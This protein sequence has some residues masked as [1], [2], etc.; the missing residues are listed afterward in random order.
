MNERIIE[1]LKK[2]DLIAYSILTKTRD[3]KS[4]IIQHKLKQTLENRILYIITKN[5]DDVSASNLKT[6]QV[7]LSKIENQ[8]YE[9]TGWEL[10]DDGCIKVGRKKDYYDYESTDWNSYYII[11]KETGFQPATRP[12]NSYFISV[13]EIERDFLSNNK[14]LLDYYH[15][16]QEEKKKI[17][18]GDFNVLSNI[19]KKEE[20]LMLAEHF[21]IK[22]DKNNIENYKK[23]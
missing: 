15:N 14:E 16:I 7:E 11:R 17:L 3:F 23:M 5:I 19:I 9:K 6:L 18:T 4:E 21:I 1:I 8:I 2:T 10:S 13:Y 12:V 22:S 20:L